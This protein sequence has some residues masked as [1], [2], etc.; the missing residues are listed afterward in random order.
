MKTIVWPEVSANAERNK[1][2]CAR[3]ESGMSFAQVGREFDMSGER[4]RGIVRDEERRRRRHQNLAPLRA[5]FARGCDGCQMTAEREQ[6]SRNG[7]PEFYGLHITDRR[8]ALRRAT[9]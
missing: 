6:R 3:R 8:A 4:V 2:I 1:M 9:R 7:A 5:A